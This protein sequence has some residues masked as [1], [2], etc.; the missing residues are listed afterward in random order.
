ME[1]DRRGKEA[2][3][4]LK[5]EVKRSKITK[6]VEKKQISDGVKFK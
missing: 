5:K 2:S 1:S 6:S 3:V 4:P